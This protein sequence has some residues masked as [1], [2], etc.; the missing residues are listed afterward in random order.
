MKIIINSQEFT[1]SETSEKFLKKYLERMHTFIQ[2]NNIETEVYEDIEER[3]AEI[4]SESHDKNISDKKVIDIVNE[5]GEPD[6]IFSELTEERHNKNIDT[7]SNRFN[8]NDHLHHNNE[9]LSRDSQNG[10][11]FGVCYGIAKKYNFDPLWVRLAFILGTFMWGMTLIAY[12]ALIFLLPNKKKNNIIMEKADELK[13]VIKVQTKKVGEKIESIDKNNLEVFKKKIV[14]KAKKIRKKINIKKIKNRF[15]SSEKKVVDSSE[16]RENTDNQFS[17]TGS[18][19]KNEIGEKNN[20]ST[21]LTSQKDQIIEKIVYREVK[22]NFII[23]FF[24]CIFSIIKNIFWLIFHSGR[25]ILAFVL[26]FI[27]IPSII[28]V[29]FTSGLI[30][31]DITINN[32]VLFHQ[33]DFFLKIGIAGLL[34]SVFFGIFG[35]FLKLLSGKTF[36]NT[37]MVSGLIGIFTFVFI[38]GLGFF[39]TAN[40]FTDV[41]THS[42]TLVLETNDLKIQDLN[43]ITNDKGI[44]WT[45]NIDFVQTNEE[46]IS[47]EVISSVNRKSQV[48]ADTIFSKVPPLVLQ[49]GNILDLSLFQKVHFTEPVPYSFYRKKIIIYIPKENINI[50]FG[51]INRYSMNN[52]SNLYYLHHDDSYKSVWELKKCEN[53]SLIF[54]PEKSGYLCINTQK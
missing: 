52:I 22:P 21:P 3:I 2:E 13:E 46:N 40:H 53:K 50:N 29:L 35:I 48:L 14:S 32:Q 25:I 26:F 15:S 20:L 44:N 16:K 30:F 36:A 42:Q 49:E 45:E 6:E 37:L 19:Q 23:R 54:Y 8:I 4:F 24:R 5:I 33:V 10:I 11:F 27:A 41:Y 1:V 9:P 39:K 7:E 38:G 34:F 12:I 43:V 51:P 28:I 18:F 47:I 17:H 31:S